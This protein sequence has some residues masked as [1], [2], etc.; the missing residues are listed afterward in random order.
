MSHQ[1]IRFILTYQAGRHNRIFKVAAP[2]EKIAKIAGFKKARQEFPDI[3][4]IQL[5][6]CRS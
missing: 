3:K 6:G 2:S 1:K 5:V 4:N